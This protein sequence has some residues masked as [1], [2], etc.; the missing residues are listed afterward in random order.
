MKELGSAF[1][2]GVFLGTGVAVSEAGPAVL[3]S[4]AL[5]ALIVISVMYAL[6]ELATALPSAVSFSTYADA[7]FGRWVGFTAGRPRHGDPVR[8]RHM[9]PSTTDG[10]PG[11]AVGHVNLRG[12]MGP[13]QAT[14]HPEVRVH[15][16]RLAATN[17]RAGYT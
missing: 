12:G 14:S 11:I 4:N 13:R 6:A 1:G 2:A 8:N 15:S 9:I 16:T 5:A 10:E 3:V 7:G 17:V